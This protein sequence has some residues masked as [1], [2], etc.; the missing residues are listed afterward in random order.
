MH[1]GCNFSVCG[2]VE[3]LFDQRIESLYELLNGRFSAIAVCEQAACSRCARLDSFG[4][5]DSLSHVCFSSRRSLYA[6]SQSGLELN[7]AC[8]IK[9]W[10]SSNL[11]KQ[12]LQVTFSDRRVVRRSSTAQFRHDLS[13]EG[14]S[15]N[16]SHFGV[17]VEQIAV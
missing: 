17:L 16:A 11:V 5:G 15:G 2:G 10:R 14:L 4:A 13:L 9:L 3:L 1:L 8:R 7:A 12:K 6:S